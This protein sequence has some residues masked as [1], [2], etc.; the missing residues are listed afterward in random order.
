LLAINHPGLARCLRYIWQNYQK[1]I[2]MAELAKTA[3]LSRAGFFKA[4][5]KKIG[6]TPGDELQ[7]VRMANAKRLLSQSQKKVDEIAELSGYQKLNS[8]WVAFR[9]STGMTPREYQKRFRI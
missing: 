2:G 3:A 4:F 7:R 5:T 8:F 1:P 6:R 9:K